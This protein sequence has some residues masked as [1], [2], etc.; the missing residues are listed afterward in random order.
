MTVAH[1]PG[2][3]AVCKEIFQ[4]TKFAAQ[5]RKSRYMC[6]AI[7]KGN[8]DSGR[9]YY[10]QLEVNSVQEEEGERAVCVHQDS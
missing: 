7:P 4:S 3:I 10:Y 9:V 6:V 2:S 5:K 1:T 8:M